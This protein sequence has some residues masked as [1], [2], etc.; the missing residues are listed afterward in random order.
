[1]KEAAL[2]IAD[3]TVSFL[4]VVIALGIV[5][6]ILYSISPSNV[7]SSGYCLGL[8][9]GNTLVWG[10]FRPISGDWWGRI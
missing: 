6:L 5:Q 9:A 3:F 1:M 4:A 8:I 2:R 7:L 10:L